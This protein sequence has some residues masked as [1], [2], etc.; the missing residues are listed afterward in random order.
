MWDSQALAFTDFPTF[1]WGLSLRLAD[2]A[3]GLEYRGVDFSAFGWGLSLRQ[4]RDALSVLYPKFPRFR[5]GT[6]IEAA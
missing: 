4:R 5:A 2:S 1:G 3:V 6:F